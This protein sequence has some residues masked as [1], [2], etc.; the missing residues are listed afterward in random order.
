LILSLAQ[1]LVRRLC[2][3]AGKEI[4]I[5]GSYKKMVDS[6]FEDLPEKFRAEIPRSNVLYGAQPT[7]ECPNGTRG[8]MAVF[9]LVE[10]TKKLENVV[11][12]NPVEPRLVE[13]ARKQGMI[14]M[15]EDAI[16]KCMKG[17]IPFEEVNTLGGLYDTVQEE[18][19]VV[20]DTGDAGEEPHNKEIVLE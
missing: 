19:D 18:D 9:E 11:L 16:I 8:R 17:L 4:P 14:T 3:G 13:I 10:M 15:Q 5:E 20:L 6:L 12:T 1:R 7:S 2:D